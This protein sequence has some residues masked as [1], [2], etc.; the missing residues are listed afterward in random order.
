MAIRNMRIQKRKR[1]LYGCQDKQQM[2]FLI[3]LS[4]KYSQR[5][6]KTDDLI[7]MKVGCKSGA[8]P[9]VFP[10]YIDDAITNAIIKTK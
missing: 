3:K 10:Y 1:T 7:D 6:N 9:V 5:L 2:F 8:V 4:F